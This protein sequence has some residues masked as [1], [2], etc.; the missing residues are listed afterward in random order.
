M[1]ASVPVTHSPSTITKIVWISLGCAAVISLL[2]L[3]SQLLIYRDWMHLRG[4]LRLIGTIVSGVLTFL[5]VRRWLLAQRQHHLENL[6]RFET[7]ARM[8]DRIR[9]SLQAIAYL[10]YMER[11][12]T[13]GQVWEAVDEIDSV[14]S[15]VLVQMRPGDVSEAESPQMHSALGSGS[16]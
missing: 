6:K 8:N 10:T 11:P 12:E 5:F 4:P 9:N 2:V 16:S 15:Q 13:L 14:L 1:N 3:L 7:I